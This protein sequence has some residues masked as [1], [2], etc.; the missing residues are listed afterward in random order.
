MYIYRYIYI[1]TMIETENI[2]VENKKD[3]QD[4]DKML[5]MEEK[6]SK[7]YIEHSSLRQW[8]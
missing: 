5:C 1:N 3:Y 8:T 4:K 2:K 6:W 7:V